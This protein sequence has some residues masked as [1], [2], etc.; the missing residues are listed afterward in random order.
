MKRKESTIFDFWN[1]C[2]C[3]GNYSRMR[4]FKLSV[5]SLKDILCLEIRAVLELS[6]ISCLLSLAAYSRNSKANN[7]MV[8]II[9]FQIKS[10]SILNCS[11]IV[12]VLAQSN[13]KQGL[14]KYCIIISGLTGVLEQWYASNNK[15]ENL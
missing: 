6:S 4:I 1:N 3:L 15:I 13:S 12:S 9:N 7:P 14:N 11:C 2:K 5:E 8:R 10:S